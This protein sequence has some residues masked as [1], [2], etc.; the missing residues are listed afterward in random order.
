MACFNSQN[1]IETVL[2][3][4]IHVIKANSQFAGNLLLDYKHY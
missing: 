4:M 2:I 3:E 1:F